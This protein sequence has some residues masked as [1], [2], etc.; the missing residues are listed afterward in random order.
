M[1]KVSGRK[2]K[3]TNI[4]AGICLGKWV[5]PLQYSGSTDCILF[6]QWFE[7]CLLEEIGRN[8]FII[9]DNASFHRKTYLTSLADCKNCKII[10][11][12]PYSPDLNLIE[13][14][15]AW[16]KQKLRELLPLTSSLDDA[17]WRAFHVE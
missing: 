7:Q 4:V 10:F 17:I 3:R 8:K 11:L 9:L 15:W 1:G 13:N 14:K 16:L 6:E 12:P 2:Y 5:A